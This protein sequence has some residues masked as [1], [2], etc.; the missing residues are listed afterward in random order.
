[1]KK[2]E[3]R[4][5]DYDMFDEDMSREIEGLTSR[6]WKIIRILEPMKWVNS[7]G[8]FIRIFYQRKRYETVA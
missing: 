1:M 7:E 8:M 2:Y 4:M 6:G 5:I 3:Y